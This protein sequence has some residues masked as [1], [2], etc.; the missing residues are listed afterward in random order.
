MDYIEQRFE[1][2]DAVMKKIDS[3]EL[4]MPVEY[5]LDGSRKPAEHT[6]NKGR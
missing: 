5:Q 6:Q 3:G 2:A 4:D 1:E